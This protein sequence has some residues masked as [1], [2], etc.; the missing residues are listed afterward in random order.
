MVKL[1]DVA[2]AMRCLQLKQFPLALALGEFEVSEQWHL[3]N[4]L[5]ARD[6]KRLMTA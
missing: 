4:H 2:S 3:N 6:Q 5:I 1:F